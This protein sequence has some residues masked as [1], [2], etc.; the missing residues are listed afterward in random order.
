MQ[1]ASTLSRS[2][3]AEIASYIKR[4]NLE[5]VVCQDQQT[6]GILVEPSRGEEP[7]PPEG[8]GQNVQHRALRSVFGRADSDIAHQSGHC[9][10]YFFRRW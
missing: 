8:R 7:V 10:R 2:D 4:D 3:L 5:A 9:C 1:D 6:G